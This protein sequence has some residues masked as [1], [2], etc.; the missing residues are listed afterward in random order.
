[1]SFM[2]DNFGNFV[3]V[4]FLVL[5]ALESYFQCRPASAAASVLSS[6]RVAAA[7]AAAAAII[8]AFIHRGWRGAAAGAVL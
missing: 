2:S 3:V 1:M 8:E 4:I 7:A 5:A 6:R